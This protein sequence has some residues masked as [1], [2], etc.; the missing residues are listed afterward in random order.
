[1]RTSSTTDP[2]ERATSSRATHCAWHR[3]SALPRVSAF[4]RR[5]WL[6]AALFAALAVLTLC[7]PNIALISVLLAVHVLVRHGRNTWN[8]MTNGQTA[9]EFLSERAPFV[10]PLPQIMPPA[11]RRFYRSALQWA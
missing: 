10:K 2:G 3:A 8:A 9:D 1:M 4:G 5:A 6:A 7:K 11:D